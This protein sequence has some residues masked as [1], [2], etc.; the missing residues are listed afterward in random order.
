MTK[1]FGCGAILQSEKP[2]EE[3]YVKDLNKKYCERCFKIT[4]YNE[5]IF[6]NKGNDEYLEK[7]AK[8]NDSNDLVLLTLDF[9]NVFD[10]NSLKIN[11]PIILL[12]TKKDLI[13]RTV[14]ENRFLSK[15][16]GKLN[17]KDSL[18]ISSKNNYNLDLL[19]SKIMKYKVSN[20]VYVVG[21]TNSGKSTLINK[22]LKNYSKNEGDITTSNLPSTTL[23]F[24]EKN[25]NDELT[26]ID[27]PG[28]L[29][30]GSVMLKATDDE[31][32][33]IIPKKEINPI[34][35]QIKTDQSI[36]FEDFLRLD[37]CKFN[38]IIVYISNEIKISRVYKDSDKLIDFELYDISIGDNQDLVIKGL[39]FIKFKKGC[40][41]KLYL[42]KGVKYFIRDS[43]V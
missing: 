4:H 22:I 31:L 33:K 16:K 27:T 25:I 9:L 26:L 2:L 13:P 17:I 19:M 11:N 37:V 29:D 39:G 43:I 30:D 21:L 20:N 14:N 7:I 3:G 8:I 23:D 32:K 42:K 24:L 1:C 6:S 41:F 38:N 18:F 12:I 28:L 10:F 36:F 35:Y 15:I 5:Y 40:N 34:I